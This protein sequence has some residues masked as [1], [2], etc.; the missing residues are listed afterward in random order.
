MAKKKKSQAI[1]FS[2]FSS[3]ID[4]VLANLD[5]GNTAAPPASPA[6]SQ[7]NAEA[8]DAAAPPAAAAKSTPEATKPTAAPAVADQKPRRG[9]KP[10]K[11][12][13]AATS[14]TS[15]S[16]TLP[17]PSTDL[18]EADL[19]WFLTNAKKVKEPTR[20][21]VNPNTKAALDYVAREAG[22]TSTSLADNVIVWFLSSNRDAIKKFIAKTRKRGNPLDDV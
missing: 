16:S 3:G 1:D 21:Y 14:R 19:E 5:T 11:E 7:G 18:P 2:A 13:R 10:G 22:L 15:K 4:D 20:L 12:K 6:V 9:K 8:K 17:L